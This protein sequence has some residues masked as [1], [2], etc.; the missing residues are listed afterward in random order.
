MNHVH[1]IAGPSGDEM[2]ALD[3]LILPGV[4]DTIAPIIEDVAFFDQ[5]WLPVETKRPRKR[6]TLA[7]NT[8]VVVRAF[9]RMDGNPERRRLGVYRLGYQVLNRD[10]SAVTE[11]NWSISFDRNPS[12]EAVKFAYAVGSKSGA[13]GETIF[14]YIVTNKVS[15]EAFS[16]GFL[17]PAQ[18]AA[19]EYVLRVFAA[20]YFG[21]TT[22]RDIEI[23]V[24]K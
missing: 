19:G 17:D 13:T 23:E 1:M 14:R 12:P 5:N 6:I 3:A 21:N 10:H 24:A 2:N 22:S 11:V 18:F 15:G 8:R 9:D 7:S 16:E 20:D 4:S